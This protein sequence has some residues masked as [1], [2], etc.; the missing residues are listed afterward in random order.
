MSRL[1]VLS[2]RVKVPDNKPMAGGLAVALQN[3]LI[4]NS[5]VWMGWNGKVVESRDNA[6]GST[7][8]FT[9]KQASLTSEG[10]CITYITTALTTK[11]YNQFYCGFANNVLWP[12]LHERTDL[13]SQ[14]PRD[15]AGY[16]D[17]NRLFAKQLKKIIEPDDVIW[18]HDYHFLSVAYHCRQ[19]GITNRIGFFLHI[20]FASLQFWKTLK[21][22]REIVHHLAHYDLVGTQTQQDRTHCLNVLQYYLKDY[23]IHDQLVASAPINV[24]DMKRNFA[25][26]YTYTR[27]KMTLNLAL[28]SQHSLMVD[29]YPIGVNV[30]QIQEQVDHLS[31]EAALDSATSN[32]STKP[33]FQ[34]IIAVDRIDYSKGLLRRFAAYRDFLAQHPSYQSHLQLL[35][36]ACPSRLDLP[37]Y[38]SLYDEV[39]KEVY[40]INQ[41]YLS[42]DSAWQAINY[43]ETALSH[44]K[45][46]TM[47]W[48][49]DIGWVN[50]LK[51][52]MNLVAKEYIAAQN[53]D[54]P[55]VLLLSRYAGAAEQMQAAVIIDPHQPRSMIEGLKTALTMPLE[56]RQSR[57]RSL[58]Q[59]LQKDNLQIWQQSFLDDLYNESSSQISSMEPANIQMSDS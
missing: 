57:Y 42:E 6:N 47:F 48:Q 13:I 11:Q 15:Y 23:F 16:Q 3:V 53:P 25:Q 9:S 10:T 19:L 37:T 52:G 46:M 50:S 45:L 7:D 18:V 39:K 51:D 20:P 1:I 59:G 12:L 43:S 35:Q 44:E 49:S 38:Q 56:E 14:K 28:K 36:V 58:L 34:Q 40:D 24:L 22:S 26:P 4:E 41:H 31:L 27:A 29:A 8:L 55:G 54:N 33:T 5:A 17:V 32:Q 30:A 21:Q 2:N